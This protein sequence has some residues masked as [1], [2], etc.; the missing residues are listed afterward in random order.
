MAP[1]DTKTLHEKG[2][3]RLHGLVSMMDILGPTITCDDCGRWQRL[4]ELLPDKCVE[5]AK[6]SGWTQ[7]NGRDLCPV[8]SKSE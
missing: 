3:Q 1:N 6:E 4:G 2:E 5:A 8:C 7:K